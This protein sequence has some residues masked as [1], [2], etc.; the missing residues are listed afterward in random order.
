G[1][2]RPVRWDLAAAVG[3][4][5]GLGVFFGLPPALAP[6]PFTGEPFFISD[7]SLNLLDVV[8]VAVGVPLGAAVAARLALRRVTTPPLGGAR[9]GTPAPPPARGLHPPPLRVGRPGVF[10]APRRPATP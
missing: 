8:L 4:P 10:L 2:V 3:P 1:G 9:P 7:L 6:I 5:F